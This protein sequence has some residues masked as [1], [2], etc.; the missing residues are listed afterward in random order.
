MDSDWLMRKDEVGQSRIEL[1]R[2]RALTC[3]QEH[4]V[5]QIFIV[6]YLLFGPKLNLGN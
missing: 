4:F 3:G 5:K 1:N 6:L 2:K